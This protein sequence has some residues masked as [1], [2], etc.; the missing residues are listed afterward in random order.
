M[1]RVVN[2]QVLVLGGGPGGYVAAL[3]AAQLGLQVVVVEAQRLGGVC[4]NRGCIPSKAL[5]HAADLFDSMSA[6]AHGAQCG[7]H[8]ESMP[9][10]DFAETQAWKQG[11]VDK[12]ANGVG[13]L[14]S[15]AKVTVVEGWGRFTDGKTCEV[16]AADTRIVAEHVILAPGSEPVELASLP[17]GGRVVSSTEALNLTAPPKRLVVVGA[18]YIGLELGVA[19]CKLGSDVVILEASN[20]ILPQ[21]DATLSKP[22]AQWLAAAG[23]TVHLQTEALG[24][25]GDALQVRDATG[26][27]SSVP[28]DTIL[29]TVGRRPALAGWGLENMA[30]DLVGRFIAVDDRCHTSMRNVWAIGDAVGEPMLEH[31][32]AA[33]GKLVAELI[34]GGRGRFNP[35]A[36]PAVCFTEPEIVVVGRA[37]ATGDDVISA[38][39]PFSAN[40]RALTQAGS[41]GFVR[42]VA[43]RDDHRVLGIHAVGR[44]VSELSG[45]FVQ[46]LEMG[47]VLEDLA[48]TIHAHP[49]LGEATHEAAMRAL[50]YPLHI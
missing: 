35:A 46:A 37:E 50:G 1:T 43:R 18:G 12:L 33:Q 22:L 32:A 23:V 41:A 11:I 10:L 45:Q 29:V 49:T 27:I 13:S 28:T 26:A 16:E 36:I 15:K 6:S 47:A 31:K 34:A 7:I 30:V 19:F 40:G 38:Q 5:I 2:T 9:R 48:H 4:L 42:V 21:Y 20:R 25:E 3:R 39:F 14:L 44:H 24:L 8:S 17:W